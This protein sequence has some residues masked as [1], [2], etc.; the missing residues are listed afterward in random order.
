MYLP[1]RDRAYYR[2]QRAKHIRRKKRICQKEYGWD[3]Y[4]HDGC[5]SKGKIHCSC[6]ICS[7]KVKTAKIDIMQKEIGNILIC[8]KSMNLKTK[9]KNTLRKDKKI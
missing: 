9:S 8:L 2:K 1:N 3:Y 5:Y 7:K 6:P 4:N